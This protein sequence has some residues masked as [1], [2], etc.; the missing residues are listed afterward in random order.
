[1]HS[2]LNFFATQANTARVVFSW[3]ENDPANDDPEN[4]SVYHGFINHGSASLNLLGGLIDMPPEPPANTV[5]FFNITVD[6]V[7]SAI[8]RRRFL[9]YIT[10]STNRM[11]SNLV[12]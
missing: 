11:F 4:G 10:T 3:N 8:Y 2:R 1:M 7:R 6:N 9:M 12:D 5:G